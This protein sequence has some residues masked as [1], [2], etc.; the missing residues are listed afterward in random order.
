MN[1]TCIYAKMFMRLRDMH[2]EGHALVGCVAVGARWLLA[3]ICFVV[4]LVPL[5]SMVR[6]RVHL[7]IDGFH[8]LTRAFRA[9][10]EAACSPPDDRYACAKQKK[11]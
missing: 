4:R 10:L 9:A 1:V 8:S 6:L 3:S 7:H 11:P 5:H 2:R